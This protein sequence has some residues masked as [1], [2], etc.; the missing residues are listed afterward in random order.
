[1]S[2]P[3]T[4]VGVKSAPHNGPHAFLARSVY[5]ST[6]AEALSWQGHVPLLTVHM[7]RDRKI[8]KNQNHAAALSNNARNVALESLPCSTCPFP[9]GNASAHR[10]K[11]HGHNRSPAA[12]KLLFFQ[13][14]FQYDSL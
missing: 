12:R 13:K 4:F 14:L 8:M 10:V 7:S 5:L 9:H 1:M 2:N 6:P 3:S 11:G